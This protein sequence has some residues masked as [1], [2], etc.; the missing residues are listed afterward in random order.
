[1]LLMV[2]IILFFGFT[3]LFNLGILPIF[4]DEAIYIRWAQLINDGKLF[5][6]LADGKTPLFMW[7]LAPLLRLGFD[8]LLTG[9]FLSVI[10]GLAIL[11]GVYLL[12]QQLFSTKVALFSSLLV[13]FCPFLFFYDRMSLT[14]SFLTAFVV[15]SVYLAYRLIKKPNL[16]SGFIL[17]LVWAG[18]LLVKPSA[19][20][21]LI[22]TPVF[23]LI[24]PKIKAL[25][26]PGIVTIIVAG[27]IYNLQR[28]SGMFYMI[29]QR[30]ADYLRPPTWENWF[31]TSRVFLNWLI[32]YLSWQVI[33]LL[34]ISFILA[35]KY[36]EKKILVLSVWVIVPFLLSAA[37]GKIVY[38]RYLLPITPFILII[39]GWG[40]KQIKFGWLLIFLFIFSWF[41]FDYL[42]LTKPEI[43]PFHQSEK[44]QY[45]YSW[46][47][48]N[49]LKEITTYL[50]QLSLDKKVV[51][52][53]EG[54]FGTLPNGLEIYFNHSENIQ[55]L[56]VG[57]PKTTVSP[58]MEQALNENN[59]VYLVVNFSRY[60]LSDE[61]RLKLV[62][63]YPRPGG[64]KLMFYEVY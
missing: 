3:R 30:S 58:A 60:N 6:P 48:G 14:D 49:G 36:R 62:A 21:Y 15:W 50:N 32:S 54:S 1:M 59:K 46:A 35:I 11:I 8:P 23:F 22:L 38:P 56:G 4:A 43:A 42:I 37:I 13:V 18:A 10:S 7:L 33:I 40:L 24:K 63:E 29:A 51:V 27:V 61:K 31:G 53:T 25:I 28:F 45:F 20:S 12:A 44:E 52:A 41:K 57:F 64:E 47:A 19:L 5:A 16:K 55:I 2:L 9:R 34:L 26:I 17:G 39:I